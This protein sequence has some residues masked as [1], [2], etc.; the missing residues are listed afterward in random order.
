MRR[1]LLPLGLMLALAACQ[2]ASP[3]NATAPAAPTDFIYAELDIADLQA[4]IARV[5]AFLQ[6]KAEKVRKG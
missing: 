2:P 5:Q 1:S 6:G 3:P 4:R